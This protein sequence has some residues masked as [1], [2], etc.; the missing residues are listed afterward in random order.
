M[1]V[2]CYELFG[3]SPL[4]SSSSIYTVWFAPHR[5]D[6]VV[7]ASSSSVKFQTLLLKT[8]WFWIS[9]EI[10][11]VMTICHFAL[12]VNS[13]GWLGLV[14]PFVSS[15]DTYVAFPQYEDVR[16]IRFDQSF[17]R[18][19]VMSL[20]KRLIGRQSLEFI[21]SGFGVNW[22]VSGYLSD[23]FNGNSDFPCIEDCFRLILTLTVAKGL[24]L[25]FSF[26]D[27]CVKK[28]QPIQQTLEKI[29][30]HQEVFACFSE[31]SWMV[32]TNVSGLGWIIKDPFKTTIQHGSYSRPFVSYA[33]VAKEL[34]L[35]A[36]ISAA[37]A[38]GLSRLAFDSDCQFVSEE[39]ME[40]SSVVAKMQS[41]EEFV[42]FLGKGAYGSVDLIKYTKTDGSS[43]LAAVKTS[44]AEILE[45]YNAL[46]REIQILSELK[47]Y[48]NIVICYEDDLEEGFNDH[49][50]QVYKLLLEYANEGS[51]S[52]FMENYTDKKL[53][54][55]MIRDFTR[56]ILEGLVSIHSHGYVHCDL[57]SDNLLIFSRKDASSYELK[58]SDFGNCREVGEVPDHWEIDF[59]FVG[60]PIYMPPESLIDGAAKKTLDLWS[61]GCL[62]LEMYTGEKP[63]AGVGIVDLV[64]FLSDGE[65]PDIP[66]CVPCDAREF[67][68]TCFARE[69]EK[70]GNAS[71]LMLHPFLC[72]EE[73]TE[74]IVVAVAKEKKTLL[75]KLK[76][77][78]KRASKITMDIRLLPKKKN[79]GYSREALEIE[80]VSI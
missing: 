11:S 59:P 33:L 25:K 77:R 72:P 70:R 79:N 43:F 67:I 22:F 15:S 63:W 42:K 28:S 71:E 50:H 36:A 20:L 21:V 57:K 16:L 13:L 27:L 4:R 78:I 10:F 61:L 19:A 6:G 37:L 74:K 35:K 52:S 64:N 68:E 29:E 65:A 3:V 26:E 54:D 34:A 23:C 17:A 38:M 46:K 41:N 44:Y 32:K 5:V 14:L 80:D 12:A 49:G 24:V 66:E 18:M 47:G 45:D 76:L 48:P 7:V 56:M 53:P 2:S 62:V 58:I 55:P 31:A 40:Q 39:T 73:K 1:V 9:P 60:T 75:V 30:A 8:P 51:L 69:H